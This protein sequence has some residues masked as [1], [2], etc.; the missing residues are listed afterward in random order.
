MTDRH[1]IRPPDDLDWQSWVDRWDRMQE[2]YLVKRGERFEVIARLIGK[3]QDRVAKVVDLGCGTGSLMLDVLT[4]FPNTEVLGIDFDPTML[5]LARARLERF[6]RRSHTELL[7][8]REP[9]WL[10]AVPAPVDAVV[11]AT[12]LHWFSPAQLAGLYQQVAHILKPGGIFLNADHVGSDF[13]AIQRE[14]ERHRAQMREQEGT[15]QSDDWDGFWAA[16]S[17][18]LRLDVNEIHQRVIGGWEGGVE[19]GLPLPWHL[20]KLREN[21]FVHVD[22]FW[23]CDCDAIY[24][25]I[26]K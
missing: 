21:G 14:W 3:T 17:S 23:R 16:Y 10:R 9:S 13:Q 6:G 19:E 7:D 5:W 8:L 4:A 15:S 26:R 22:C 12:A 25:G 2:R 24:G 18:A 11:S 1:D 20:D